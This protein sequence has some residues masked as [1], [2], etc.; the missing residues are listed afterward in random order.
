MWVLLMAMALGDKEKYSNMASSQS[1]MRN[2]VSYQL[3]E[4]C[5]FKDC[6]YAKHC[7]P[8]YTILLEMLLLGKASP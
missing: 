4:V 2:S 6:A 3:I 5:V 8:H 1:L 7:H